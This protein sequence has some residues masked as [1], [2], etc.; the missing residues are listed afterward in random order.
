ME[1]DETGELLVVVQEV[2]GSIPVSHPN[3]SPVSRSFMTLGPGLANRRES[4]YPSAMTAIAFRRAI[5]ALLLLALA[6]AAF[7]D[8]ARAQ[9]YDDG[10]RAYDTGDFA[11]ALEI[12]GPLA[13][14]G[15]AVAQ[16]S[17]GK[18]LE[19]GGVGVP[20]DLAEAAKWY[21]RSAS[22]GIAA[23]QNNLGLMYA[24]GRGVPQDV[25]LAVKFWRDAAA[26]DHVVAKFNLA[27]AYFRGEG[28]AEDRVEARRWFR[29]SAELGLADAQYALAQIIRMGL[30]AD[31]DEAEALHWY[32]L[33]AAQGHVKAE[34]QARQLRD[35]GV[36]ARIPL[37]TPLPVT[38]AVAATEPLPPP[39][40][41]EKP[42][43]ESAVADSA[44]APAPELEIATVPEPEIPAAPEPEI[45][46]APEPAVTAAATAAAAPEAAPAAATPPA[47]AE[48]RY[49]AW[50]I[51]FK[52]AA[53]ARAYLQAAQS[54]HPDLFAEAPGAVS[55]AQ[56]GPGAT[57]H[58]VLAGG[59][60]SRPAA[61]DLCRRLRAAE[62]G[63][64][65][66]VLAN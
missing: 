59:L 63:A 60:S 27:L 65:C 18:L 37:G 42:A 4:H 13:E 40:S 46:P 9:S 51:S 15:D 52:D 64:F 21:Q 29:A 33:A 49:S 34:A 44:M 26:K 32:Q 24:Q 66:K 6:G 20:R 28:V 23:A 2:A 1:N 50:L 30:T 10:L 43:V 48:G 16:Y 39:K 17:L 14:N 47:I 19:N 22:Q 58:R 3:F 56:P 41:V 36:I 45:A 55:A 12:W 54:K 8:D 38:P 62:P 7:G 11:K 61:R 5:F 57:F 35:A 31:A 25:V 53:E